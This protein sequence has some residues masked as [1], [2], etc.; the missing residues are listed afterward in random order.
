MGGE[1]RGGCRIRGLSDM[2]CAI[3]KKEIDR[4]IE[5]AWMRNDRL[6]ED[7]HLHCFDE[8]FKDGHVV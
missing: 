3:C 6:N 1:I 5:F 2:I 7:Y 4:A 8:K